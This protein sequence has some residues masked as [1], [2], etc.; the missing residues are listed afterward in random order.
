MASLRL[1]ALIKFVIFNPVWTLAA[2]LCRL[3]VSRKTTEKIADMKRANKQRKQKNNKA[4]RKNKKGV[5][6]TSVKP[7]FAVAAQHHQNG[8]TAQAAKIYQAILNAD[9]DHTPS[10]NN[11]GMIL[12]GEGNNEQA[13]TLFSKAIALA[14]ENARSHSSMAIALYQ[15]G[16]L[17]DSL[18]SFRKSLA[19]NPVDEQSHFNLGNVLKEI[20]RPLEAIASY[21]EALRLNPGNL[22]AHINI[23]AI[24]LDQYNPQEAAVCFRNVLL[25]NPG[26]AEA[27]FN[28]GKALQIMEKFDQAAA[29]FDTA[30]A[31]N[32]AYFEALNNLGNALHNMGK[33]NQAEG[34]YRQALVIKPDY[35]EALSNLG[36]TLHN[37]GKYDQ[38]EGAYRKAMAI[39]PDYAEAHGN[40]IFLQD[41]MPAIDQRGQQAER[42]LWDNAFIRPLVP[43]SPAPYANSR[44]PARRLRIGYVSADFRDHSAYLGFGPLIVDHDRENFD[45]TCYDATIT[46]DHVSAALRSAATHWRDIRNISDEALAKTIRED[47]IDILVDLSGHSK[48][49][50]LKVFAYKPAPLQATG[51]GH[52]PPGIS[53]MDYRL[54]TELMTPPDEEAIYPEKPIYLNTYF[55]FT[56]SPDW[57]PVGPSPCLTNGFITF[58]YLG[59]FSKVS[60]DALAVWAGILDDV[61]SARLL[62]KDSQFDDPAARQKITALFAAFGIAAERLIF[63]GKTN[64]HEHLAAHNRVDILLDSFPHGGGITVMESI[65]MGVP[66]IGLINPKKAGGRII[67]SICQPLGLAQ[68][69]TRSAA[70][71]RALAVNWAG[72]DEALS[73]LRQQLRQRLWAVYASFP[74][75]VEKAYRMI[76]QRWCRGEEPD[77]L[78]PLL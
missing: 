29:S 1:V 62:L 7:D 71:Y 46:G 66:V 44:E 42:K 4:A 16:R 2:F 21:R 31:I 55:G 58:G 50:R 15:L 69:S 18:L 48:G 51:I 5:L 6:P 65:W 34:A 14:P 73:N 54:T 68:W 70:D 26:I 28:L 9:G 45:V 33:L 56:P 72:R 74:G 17:D 20:E 12:T 59:R 3:R 35:A 24:L 32:P 67:Q 27:H 30:L 36:N 23:G 76:W 43:A 25:T 52:L 77:A 60:D 39:K 40:L 53:T 11:L 19:I 64:R 75:D 13:I 8:R 41:F 38:A 10:L 61:A 78:Y 47:S 49:N 22:H 57:P 63:L 37:L